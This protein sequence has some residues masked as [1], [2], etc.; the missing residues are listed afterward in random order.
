M[1]NPGV[2]Q[3]INKQDMIYP[4]SGILLSHEKEQNCD[5]NTHYDMDKSWKHYDN[6][7]KSDTKAQILI[8][9]I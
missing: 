6:W 1:N 2:H 5:I 8:W 7:S 3:Q 4:Y 9:T